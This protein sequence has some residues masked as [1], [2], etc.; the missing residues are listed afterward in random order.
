VPVKESMYQGVCIGMCGTMEEE[1]WKM[2]WKELEPTDK[3]LR[4][5]RK[6]ENEL[7]IY[8]RGETR[9]DAY[10]WIKKNADD[11]SDSISKSGHYSYVI[12]QEKNYTR[13]LLIKY[14]NKMTE[15]GADEFLFGPQ[16]EMERECASIRKQLAELGFS[17][18]LMDEVLNY[19][20]EWS[21][22]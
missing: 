10:E 17:T 11:Y 20:D 4:F 15:K 12:S 18:K 7:G 2:N 13:V 5:I 9:N 3:Q 16:I 19:K 6:I 8:F 22:K 14:F 21:R 1:A